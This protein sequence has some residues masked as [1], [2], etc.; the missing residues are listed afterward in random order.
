MILHKPTMRQHTLTIIALGH[1]SP[2]RA[3]VVL[4]NLLCVEFYL[5]FDL[6][7][8]AE[9]SFSPGDDLLMSF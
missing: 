5:R 6:D 1:K 4:I 2:R 9:F 8:L 3:L 7:E